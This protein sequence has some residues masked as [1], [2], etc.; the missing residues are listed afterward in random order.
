MIIDTIKLKVLVNNRDD[1]IDME[2]CSMSKLASL[3][4]R[5]IKSIEAIETVEFLAQDLFRE[6]VMRESVKKSNSFL[7]GVK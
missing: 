7:K 1:E 4:T 5:A 2:K 6:K 3:E